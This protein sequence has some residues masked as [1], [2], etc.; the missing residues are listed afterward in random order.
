[1]LGVSQLS[2]HVPELWSISVQERADFVQLGSAAFFKG[3][4]GDHNQWCSKHT[5]DS[6]L[7]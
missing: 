3:V 5:P 7:E 4:G 1:M 2:F 6:T